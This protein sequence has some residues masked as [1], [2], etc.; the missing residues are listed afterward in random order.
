MKGERRGREG[1]LGEEEVLNRCGQDRWHPRESGVPKP[2]KNEHSFPFP[3]RDVPRL[4]KGV[5]R[6]I[7]TAPGN[8]SRGKA[9][10]RDT[11]DKT[12]N[13]L[14]KSHLR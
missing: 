14:H 4:S 9:H 3:S 1:G 8:N 6:G 10:P 5:L 11:K 2:V 7:T 13:T 12:S